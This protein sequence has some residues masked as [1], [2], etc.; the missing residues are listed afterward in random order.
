MKRSAIKRKTPMRRA[1]KPSPALAYDQGDVGEVRAAAVPH[2]KSLRR[3]TYGPAE[4]T[5]MPKSPAD[6]NP[7]VRDL[8]MGE[9]CQVR[10]I[11]VCRGAGVGEFTVWAHTNT[12]ADGKGMGYKGH[13]SEGM[14]ACDRCHEAIDRRLLSPVATE[15]IV[16]AAKQRTRIRLRF[17]ANDPAERQWRRRAAAW[18]IEQQDRRRKPQ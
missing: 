14:L 11:P 10:Y 6:R 13:D 17:I 3:G 12:Q 9:E 8:A 15:K 1:R 5:P 2:V 18:V 4:L 16:R 7:A